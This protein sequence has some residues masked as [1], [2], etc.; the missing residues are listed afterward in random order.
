MGLAAVWSQASI[1]QGLRARV[2]A[3]GRDLALQRS[4]A[5]TFQRAAT[6]DPTTGIGN[7]RAFYALL[8]ETLAKPLWGS[9]G[10]PALVLIDLDRFKQ[11]NDTYGHSAG[12]A[13]LARVAHILREEMRRQ[14]VVAR[15]GGDEFGVLIHRTTADDLAQVVARLRRVATTRPLYSSPYGDHIFGSFSVGAVLLRDHPEM[16]AALLA[17]DRALYRDKARRAEVGAA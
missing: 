2:A 7:R 12:D 3:L 8:E 16:D 5:Q 11:I 10:G 13:V 15:L 1:T 6:T 9:V 14:D 4:L 17:A